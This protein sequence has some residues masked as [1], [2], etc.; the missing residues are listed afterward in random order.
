MLDQIPP[1][2]ASFVPLGRTNPK[3]QEHSPELPG[4]GRDAS[5]KK[6]PNIPSSFQLFKFR[7]ADGVLLAS[8]AG[9]TVFSML[10]STAERLAQS[11]GATA[12]QV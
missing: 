5:K 9:C 3:D 6:L 4:F 7:G 8:T 11:M 1:S 10:P 2:R 12:E